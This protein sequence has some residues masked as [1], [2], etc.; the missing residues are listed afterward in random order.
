MTEEEKLLS[1]C[2]YVLNGSKIW[3]GMKW[4]YLPIHPYKYLKARE[5]LDAYWKEKQ[6]EADEK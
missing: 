2:S 1:I 3:E 6:R 4:G 5:Q